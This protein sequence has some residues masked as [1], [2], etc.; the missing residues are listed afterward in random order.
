MSLADDMWKRLRVFA[1]RR[2][3]ASAPER[4]LDPNGSEAHLEGYVVAGV[5]RAG[6]WRAV[7]RNASGTRARFVAGFNAAV[8]ARHANPPTPELRRRD[9]WYDEDVPA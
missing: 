4:Y 6:G 5:Q 7:Q 9:G 8:E 1:E 3:S 2:G